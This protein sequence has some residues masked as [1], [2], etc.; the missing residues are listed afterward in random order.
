MDDG[1]V[2][3][4]G[5]FL[6]SV[7]DVMQ[8]VLRGVERWCRDKTLS[9]NP[10]KTEMI[11]FTRRYKPEQ[12][13][14]IYFHEELKLSQCQVPRS[15]TRSQVELEGPPGFWISKGDCCL[16]TVEKCHWTYLGNDSEV[17]HWLYNTLPLY[18]QCSVK[19]Q[20]YCGPVPLIKL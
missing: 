10:S 16:L 6:N 8:R 14:A 11:L 13:K 20:S 12:Q 3:V 5:K 7:C 18:D 4:C 19:R 17:V 9:V 1:V 15:N 2:L